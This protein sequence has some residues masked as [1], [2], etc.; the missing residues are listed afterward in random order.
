MYT[1][2]ITVPVERSAGVCE[3]K[4]E[5]VVC[6]LVGVGVRDEGLGPCGA[7]IVYSVCERGR[8]KGHRRAHRG[9]G[10]RALQGASLN[11]DSYSPS[12]PSG[13]DV[14]S[15]CLMGL[16]Q[17]R[18]GWDSRPSR[19]SPGVGRDP[20]GPAY[21]WSRHVSLSSR[22]RCDCGWAILALLLGITQ[23]PD[24]LVLLPCESYKL[25]APNP[26]AALCQC[27]SDRALAPEH[28][29][30]GM[31]HVGTAIF[32]TLRKDALDCRGPWWPEDDM[33]K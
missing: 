3:C 6:F 26:M 14:E 24:H 13:R 29:G 31:I 1:L 5:W 7:E 21:Q 18:Q 25:W 30:L 19:H 17:G 12:L 8:E 32:M 11:S 27:R 33:E 4:A 15:L 2:Q 16:P 23:H 22:W 20:Q 28:L 10:P 9:K